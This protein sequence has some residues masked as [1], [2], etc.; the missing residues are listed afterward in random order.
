MNGNPVV[1][2]L[3][4]L[5]TLLLASRLAGAAARY[6]G[7]PRVLGELLVGVL[8]GPTFLDALH[9][10]VF[11]GAHLE[12]SL[13]EM[14]ELG[15]ILLMFLVGLEVHLEELN[16]VR[17][18]AMLAG[19]LGALVPVVFAFVIVQLDGYSWEPALFAGVTL[20]ATS[21]SISAQVL[22]ELGLLRR[23]EGSALLATALID[24]ILAIL[25]VSI[26]I[27]ITSG[28]GSIAPEELAE[29]V[30]RMAAFLV[31]GG[32]IAWFVLP[33]LLDWIAGQPRLAQSYGLPVMALVAMLFYGW[34]AEEFGGVAAITGAFLA[35]LGVSQMR[36][37]AKG[38]IEDAASYIAY[39]FLV[40]LFFVGVGLQTDLSQFPL[41]AA[42]LAIALIVAAV[43]SKIG[44]AGLGALLGGF[45]RRQALRLG[46]CMIS[47]GEVGL[48]IATLGV[49][50]GVL[51]IG[52][53]L[54]STLF[55]V[56]ILTTVMTPPL[57]RWVFH[58]PSPP[59]LE[60]EVG[61]TG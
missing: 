52:D 57:V 22:L 35:G 4:A 13:H 9:W 5:G 56:I 33:R 41:E 24:D 54:F 51:E 8:L 2:L 45:E 11:H 42:P 38:E 21:V 26:T 25:L 3:L 27:A 60:L 40:P 39:A 61:G 48:I 16:R 37:R 29:I 18:V 15:V 31:V 32:L 20:A 34:A 10:G 6:M 50:S 44:G 12:T 49:S 1:P 46:V 43:L 14:A 17:G 19:V 36:N 23:V 30:L 47:R 28:E 58:E 55:L 53:P 7:Q 59:E